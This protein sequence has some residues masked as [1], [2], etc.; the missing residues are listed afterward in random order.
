MPGVAELKQRCSQSVAEPC[1]LHE[2]PEAQHAPADAEQA[3]P[4]AAAMTDAPCLPQP[5]GLL[6]LGAL[7]PGLPSKQ[8]LAHHVASRSLHAQ[9]HAC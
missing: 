6:L 2:L 8:R 3:A 9:Q 5:E 1:L 4:E 7:S